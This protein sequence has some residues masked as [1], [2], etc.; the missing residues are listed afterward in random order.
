MQN[1][2]MINR[3]AEVGIE[4]GVASAS[5]HRL[6]MMLLEGAITS[7]HHSKREMSLGNINTKGEAITKAICIIGGL[8]SSL[9]LEAGGNIAVNLRDLY[10]YM[11]SKLIEGNMKNDTKKLDEVMQLL[12]D[13]KKGWEGIESEARVAAKVGTLQPS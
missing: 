13:L 8:D 6:I 3:Y 2:S 7:I 11:T 5:P 12:S 4:T 9:N 1:Q 10:E